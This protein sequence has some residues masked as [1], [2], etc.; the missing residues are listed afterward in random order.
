MVAY[1][2]GRKNNLRA[3]TNILILFKITTIA[4]AKTTTGMCF[5][6]DYSFKRKVLD[7]LLLTF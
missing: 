7:A 5:M 4:V 1:S 3:S 6:G 2:F